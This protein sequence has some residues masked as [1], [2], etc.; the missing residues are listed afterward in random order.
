MM[1]IKRSWVGTVAVAV[2]AIAASTGAASAQGA[3][4]AGTTAVKKGVTLGAGKLNVT[5]TL[6]PNVSKASVFKP[7]SIAPDISFGV[8]DKL[9]LSIVHSGAA[10]TGFRGGA[11]SGLCVS[12][13]DTGGCPEA[14]RNVGFEGLYSVLAGQVAAAAS[15]G[16]HLGP[17]GDPTMARVKIGARSRVAAGAFAVLFNP[18]VFIAANDRGPNKDSAFLPVALTYKAAPSLTA[19]LGT[20][21]KLPDLSSV[22]DGWQVPIG[23][24]GQLQIAPPFAV[25]ASFVFGNAV[26]GSATKDGLDGRFVQLWAS[27]TL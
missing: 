27:Y 11:G 17:L 2:L 20:G 6:E 18:S 15:V 5:L 10:V 23:V 9:T 12:G 24:F 21:L 8:T 14:Y 26:G 16:L 3:P 25:G 4:G 7:F 13:A 19:G 22:G 1:K